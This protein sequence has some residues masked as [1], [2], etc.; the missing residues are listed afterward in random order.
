M[1]NES[2]L[3]NVRTTD[4]LNNLKINFIHS[5]KDVQNGWILIPPSGH[6]IGYTKEPILSDFKEDPLL[7]KLLENKRIEKLASGKFQ[8]VQ[9]SDN[10]WLQESDITSYMD[11]MLHYITKEDRFRGYAWLLHSDK[12]DLAR[13]D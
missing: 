13:Q 6:K 11:L 1:F 10:I 2:F 4:S 7:N 3:D 8:T 5:L 12:L 9:G